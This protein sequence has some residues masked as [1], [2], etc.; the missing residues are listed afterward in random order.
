MLLWNYE[1][2]ARS[3]VSVGNSNN[4][5]NMPFIGPDKSNNE[6]AICD[7]FYYSNNL[8]GDD[9][10]NEHWCANHPI[11]NGSKYKSTEYPYFLVEG[12]EVDFL[13]N[14]DLHEIPL[15]AGYT[16]GH[17]ERYLSGNTIR[18][19][20]VKGWAALYIPERWK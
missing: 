16:D 14:D 2:F 15:N 13:T 4:M 18:Q 20:A 10:V 8:G 7:S 6:L 17:V 9:S 3:A 19:Q 11:K 1:A 5:Y 12:R